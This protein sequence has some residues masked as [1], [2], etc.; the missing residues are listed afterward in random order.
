VTR[1][2]GRRSGS[3]DTRAQVLAAARH[4]FADGG[5]E[6]ATIRGIAGRAGVDPALVHH[7][8]GSKRE[9]FRAAMQLPVDV[10]GMVARIVE[11]P[12][13][14]LGER[15]V[16]AALEQWEHPASRELFLGIIR[17]ATTDP[18]AAEML[19]EI[20]TEG[21]LL[22]LASISDRPD[23]RLRGTL[24]GSQIVGLAMA[25]YVVG[26][27]PLASASADEV[28]A[29]VGPTLQRYLTDDLR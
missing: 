19:R 14:Q 1:R 17:S 26:V 4:E 23:A 21:P 5:F 2:T 16:R 11:G 9:L 3:E 27:E 20:L 10:E 6:R 13:D 29:A 15:F 25:R 24:A 7:Y 18:V 8:F 22:A 12:R 28:A